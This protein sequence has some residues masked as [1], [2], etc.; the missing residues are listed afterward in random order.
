PGMHALGHPVG[1]VLG[2][3]LRHRLE[4]A[5]LDRVVERLVEFHELLHRRLPLGCFAS[6]AAQTAATR[7]ASTF[8]RTECTRTHQAPARAASALTATVASSHSANGRGVPS[9]PASSRP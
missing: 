3:D 2:P 6:V 4:V 7:T 5:A 1:G 9:G 8:G